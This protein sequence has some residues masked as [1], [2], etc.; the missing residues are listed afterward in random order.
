[1]I[2]SNRSEPEAEH[3]A[4]D[5]Q[6]QGQFVGD[7]LGAAP[8]PAQETV[9]V[10]AGPTAQ[11]HAVDGD[12][13]H[14]ED[15]DHAHVDARRDHQVDR[16]LDAPA[17]RKDAVRQD[18]AE[19]DH[20]EDRDRRD[21]NRHGGEEVQALIDVGGR[22][23]GLEEK[24]HAVGQRLAQAEQA[25]LGQR[26]ADPVRAPAVLDPGG[27]PPLAQH[28]VGGSRHQPGDYQ[29][30]LDQGYKDDGE[31]GEKWFRSSSLSFQVQ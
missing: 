20:G 17:C 9:F 19:G 4:E 8:Q 13:A 18:A 28:Q 23:F 30:D 16:L 14:G 27:D 24:L 3:H 26:N 1:M 10:V 12:A 6:P 7:Q 5:A 25:D 22:V 31:H 15:E 2:A 11:N 21:E 29:D